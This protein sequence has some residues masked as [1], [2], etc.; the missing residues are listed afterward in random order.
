MKTHLF[1]SA[2]MILCLSSLQLHA[3]EQRKTEPERY[4]GNP[5]PT[6]STDKIYAIDTHE[7]RG[8]YLSFALGPCFGN[9]HDDVTTYSKNI[10]YSGTGFAFDFRIGGPV[11]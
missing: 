5:A 10:V 4:Q 2:L 7:H 6:K 3:Q 8:V 9:I 1:T 11:E